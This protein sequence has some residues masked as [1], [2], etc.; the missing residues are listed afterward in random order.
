VAQVTF[1]CFQCEEE[2]FKP[3]IAKHGFKKNDQGELV[4]WYVCRPCHK[5]WR[6]ENPSDFD[7]DEWIYTEVGGWIRMGR[8]GVPSSASLDARASRGVDLGKR[9]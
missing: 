3:E 2:K 7:P 1:V 9:R 5:K 4:T 8:N 6:E